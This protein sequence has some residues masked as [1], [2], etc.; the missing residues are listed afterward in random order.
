[1]V[2]RAVH[3]CDITQVTVHGHLRNGDV[4]SAP[5]ISSFELVHLFVLWPGRLGPVYSAPCCADCIP[6]R[7]HLV[8]RTFSYS[9]CT[10]HV[11]SKFHIS[12][13]TPLPLHSLLPSSCYVALARSS[14]TFYWFVILSVFAH[15]TGINISL[16][17]PR[18]IT[19]FVASLVLRIMFYLSLNKR[20]C[21]TCHGCKVWFGR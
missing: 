8:I 21:N 15:N 18:A 6:W 7:L 20:V 1:M 4:C 5:H 19:I 11:P 2:D 13:N 17:A 14:R 16:H 12:R 3:L 9:Q 10:T